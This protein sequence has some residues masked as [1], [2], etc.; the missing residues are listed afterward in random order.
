VQLIDDLDESEG[1]ETIRYAL[2]GQEYEI[3]LRS[4]QVR[5]TFRAAGAA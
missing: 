1:V 4:L 3:D 5:S 2:D